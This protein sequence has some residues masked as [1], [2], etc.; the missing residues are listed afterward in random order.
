MVKPNLHSLF[1]S[2]ILRKFFNK[3]R[4]VFCDFVKFLMHM[5][6]AFVVFKF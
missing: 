6:I 1:M 5:R 3:Y 4:L 2:I